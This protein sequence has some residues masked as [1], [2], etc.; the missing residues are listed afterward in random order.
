MT[1]E[2]QKKLKLLKQCLPKVIQSSIKPY[3]FKKKDY[4]VWYQKNDMYF[5]LLV[6]IRERDGHCYCF[7]QETIKPLWLDD[8]FWDMIDMAENKS[9]PLSLRCIGAFALRGMENYQDEQ[10]LSEWS[11]DELEQCVVAYMEHFSRTIENSDIESYYSIFD[12]SAY[13]G[14][15]QEILILIHKGEYPKALERVYAIEGNGQFSNKGIWFKEYAENY[16]K[17]CIGECNV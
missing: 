6:G 7:S 9:Q 17:K 1:R 8:L 15:I 4:M 3:G 11:A 13:Q 5:S 12:P 2:Q 16:C 10:E 14:Y